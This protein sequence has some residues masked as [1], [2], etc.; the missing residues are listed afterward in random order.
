MPRLNPTKNTGSIE[1]AL[2]TVEEAAKLCRVSAN[3]WMRMVQAK[4]APQPVRI[5]RS[6]RFP[7]ET[8]IRW[9]EEGCPACKE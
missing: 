3:H 1:S 5:G 8:V 4:K 9:I 7:R 6:V 2:L